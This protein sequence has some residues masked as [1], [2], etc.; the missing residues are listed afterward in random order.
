MSVRGIV[1]IHST[2]TLTMKLT[3]ARFS[4]LHRR[5]EMQ[6]GGGVYEMPQPVEDSYDDEGNWRPTDRMAKISDL[7]S[8]EPG[9]TFN[10][11]DKHF[12]GK[13]EIKRLA[14]DALIREGYVEVRQGA[15][16]AQEHVLVKRYLG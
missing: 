11:I 2:G 6:V 15:R 10:D 14:I 1:D 4:G 3:R 7:L 13:R 8:V 16:N 12:S 5:L 9:L